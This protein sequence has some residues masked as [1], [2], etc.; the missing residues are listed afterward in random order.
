MHNHSKHTDSLVLPVVFTS[1]TFQSYACY[2]TFGPPTQSKIISFQRKLMSII[3]EKI[4][5][6]FAYLPTSTVVPVV[7]IMIWKFSF[8][9]FLI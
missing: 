5:K 4:S 3:K 8:S 9:F 6:Q 1:S 7:M 2:A